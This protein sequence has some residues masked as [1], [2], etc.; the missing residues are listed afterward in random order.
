MWRIRFLTRPQCTT[1]IGIFLQLW[2]LYFFLLLSFSLWCKEDVG[3]LWEA[4]FL[5]LSIL[6]YQRFPEGLWLKMLALIF[7]TRVFS[8]RL[9]T[10]RNWSLRVTRGSMLTKALSET[11]GYWLQWLTS[12]FG[13]NSS[14][15]LFHQ[16][17]A[18]PK[19]ML[20]GILFLLCSYILLLISALFYITVLLNIPF[21]GFR[22]SNNFSFKCG[23]SLYRSIFIM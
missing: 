6:R 7:F 20:V 13:T 2:T 3:N 19:T 21:I 23:V 4:A 1:S 12:H 22:W 9:W 8:R 14:T 10:S 16:I 11:A 17:K 18:S 5:Y 15:E